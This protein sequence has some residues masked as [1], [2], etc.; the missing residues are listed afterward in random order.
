[1]QDRVA[2][3]DEHRFSVCGRRDEGVQVGGINVFPARVRQV[4]L[5]HPQVTDAVVRLMTPDE[6][7][8]LK[9]FVVNARGCDPVALQSALWA[10]AEARLT[11]PERPKAFTFGE[12]LPRNALGKLSD[13][14]LDVTHHT[15][16]P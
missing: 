6:G 2:W 4:L 3:R 8:R 11:V 13:W 16:Q 9:A 15:F 7:S 10:W 1:M 5:D 12:H 14:P